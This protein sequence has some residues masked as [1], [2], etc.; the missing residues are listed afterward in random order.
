MTKHRLG[1]RLVCI[2]A[3]SPVV[4]SVALS[5]CAFPFTG[6]RHRLIRVSG[7]IETTEQ[8]CR[9]RVSRTDGRLV[10]DHRVEAKF[11]TGFAGQ[12]ASYL[13][14]VSCGAGQLKSR[15][16]E[17]RPTDSKTVD[18]G[19]IR[20]QPITELVGSLGPD[21]RP[22]DLEQLR[23]SGRDA[24]KLLI[25]TLQ[26]ISEEKVLPADKN[27]HRAAVHVVW[28]LRALRYLTGK[29]F[30]APTAHV[31]GADEDERTREE[32]LKKE[33]DTVTFFATWM[34]RDSVYIAPADAQR[35]I[36]E[37]WRL[38]FS[39]QDETWRPIPKPSID[40]WY[41]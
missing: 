39:E 1:R 12:G 28:A 30:R 27:A 5:S 10:V 22:D 2:L 9:I 23:G 31:F 20:L 3:L 25:E 26:P 16:I 40:D 18:L 33:D 13:A 38:W 32:L 19:V 7:Q 11:Q 35:T 36:I 14:E 15:Q 4:L 34:S 6:D 41:F 21:T 8:D 29:N 37:A 17:F 24:V